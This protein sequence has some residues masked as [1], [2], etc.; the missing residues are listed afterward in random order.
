MARKLSNKPDRFE[1]K[2]EPMA[3][4]ARKT[5]DAVISAIRAGSSVLSLLSGL[6]AAALI[7]YSG[8]V[9]YDS[10]STQQ[11]AYSSSWE[12]L[13]Y[14]PE[15]ISEGAEPSGG[16]ETLA[17]IT[18][19]YR[20]WLTVYDSGIDYPLV[21]GKD[22]LY[23]ASRDVY[24]NISLTGAIYLAAANSRDFSDSY[25]L[26]YGH[27]MDNG[28]MFG[29]LDG[30]RQAD[31]FSAHRGGIVV[32]ESG[33]YDLTVFAVVETDAYENQIYSVGNRAE[34][35]KAFLTGSR[36]NDVGLGTRIL[37]LDQAVLRGATKIVALS[38]C[39]N[40]ETNGRLVV[41][42]AMRPRALPT[43]T[44]TPSPTPTPTPEPTATPEETVALLEG[45]EGTP[46]PTPTGAPRSGPTPTPTPHPTP[47]PTPTLNPGPYNLE[48]RY[49]F[50]DGRI[51]A[52]SWF[53]K[54]MAGEE[55]GRDNPTIPGYVTA[56][57]R[58]EGIMEYQDAVIVV[59]YIPEQIADKGETISIDEY[60]VP[61][62]LEN[63]HAQMGV[64]I[65]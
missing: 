9:L 25:N 22:D 15:I 43:V 4:A 8:Y 41:F 1:E 62:G 59:L 28:A 38:T 39:D 45:A 29:A 64:C 17:A 40:A 26:I 37:H 58:V 56:R 27:H 11:R 65:E 5:A 53:A 57:V 23:Y 30:Y 6:L 55:Y 52:P 13:Q 51:A 50:I 49:E 60:E 24:Q 48:V 42:A 21:Q 36:E 32:T 3:G 34:E 10:F 7:L 19:D 61:L 14:K 44:P 46:T 33:A 16:K 31:F 18:K 12:L 20:G 35:V 63:L 54:K 47:V 2:P